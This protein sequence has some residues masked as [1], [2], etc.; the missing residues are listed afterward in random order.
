MRIITVLIA[1]LFL[2][3][4]VSAD[5]VSLSIILSA[6]VSAAPFITGAAAFSW[7]V[8]AINAAL[9]FALN[10]LAPK[11]QQQVDSGYRVNSRGGTFPHAI[12][13][14]ETI[15]A[16]PT[17]YDEVTDGNKYLHRCIAIAGHECEA[18]TTVYFNDEALTLDGAGEITAPSK[19]V[20]KARVNIHLGDQTTADSDLVAESAG[21]WTTNHIAYGVCYAYVRFKFNRDAF[22]RGV[23]VVTFLVQGALVYDPRTT[24]TV[25]SDNAALCA[26]DYFTASYGLNVDS[27]NI[28]D[29]AY[30]A[31]ANIC[32]ETVALDAGG[33]EKRYTIN[34]SF[35]TGS[36]PRS[37]VTSIHAAM[38]GYPVYGQGEWKSIAGAFTSATKTLAEDDL[39]SNLSV[40]PKH[41]RA[42]NF[43]AVNGIFK[44]VE[45]N[46]KET[47]Y[48]PI[49]SA[50]FLAEDGGYSNVAEF[51]LP[52]T[53]TSTAAQ[54]IAKIALYRNR[55]QISLSAQFGL[56][57]YDIEVGEVIQFSYDRWGW[58]SKNFE[59]VGWKFNMDDKGEPLVEL[60]L[61]EI[62]SGVFD[63]SAEEAEFLSN[64]TNLPDAFITASVGITPSSELRAFNEK[65]SVV[66]MVDVT[67][68]VAGFVQ[69]F[70]VEA[71]K[72]A[73]TTW[74]NLGTASGSHFEL[75]DAEDVLYDIRA[76]IINTFGVRGD[77]TQQD[78]YQVTASSSPPAD[79]TN[80]NISFL[81][82]SAY[83]SWDAVADLDLSHYIIR[84][85]TDP[86]T[87]DYNTSAL[88]V[89]KVSRPATSISVPAR[90]G[91]Y[92]IRAVDKLGNQSENPTKI[93]TTF[94]NV[95]GMNVVETITE[96]TGF[97]GTYT[98]TVLNTTTQNGVVLLSYATAPS[99]GSYEFNNQIDLGGLYTTR[100]TG[101]LLAIRLDSSGEL[102]DASS[103]L[104]DSKSGLFDGAVFSDV[105]IKIQVAIT[106]DDPTG[107]PTWGSWTDLIAG[108]FLGWGFK[109]QVLLTS[110]SDDVTPKVIELSV[111]A[112]MEDRIEAEADLVSGAGSYAVTFSPVFKSLGG[113]GISAQ[114]LATGD[115][116]SITSKSSTGFTITFK[117]SSGTDI[118]RTFDYVAK[119]YGRL[120]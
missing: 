47:S 67:S 52:F 9:G 118:S 63:W 61:R 12:I 70:E 50:T 17:F 103:G 94:S 104:F 87:N 82:T 80:F 92:F 36:T 117:N 32:D 33:T 15:V 21:I 113:V 100:L 93:S 44:G 107:S 115:Y 4:P 71:R 31:Q 54:R 1:L 10:L 60:T 30:I 11:P 74:T 39:R 72:S 79:V 6:A 62:S 41:A 46:Y 64:N 88:L 101:E 7:T 68:S 76:R 81:S 95:E 96:H 84:Y 51:N 109:F 86:T 85:S 112:D 119:G 116:Y 114:G 25:Y 105:N 27:V 28:N 108:D 2:A 90:A 48:P 35:T 102:F 77:W 34:G 106:E 56:N 58:A 45:T 40:S 3:S 29:T 18:V 24:T 13:Y 120:S 110:D 5:P 69:Q 37:I 89:E 98:D 14:G 83:L 23:P 65:V 57:A 22:P 75:L 43:N 20:G 38:A 55:E 99:S 111:T 91:A 59:C 78:D 26:R 19:W 42:E 8:F 53:N 66:L 73:D 97:T 49:T 16:G